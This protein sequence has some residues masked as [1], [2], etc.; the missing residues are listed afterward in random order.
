MTFLQLIHNGE[1]RST[2]H[3]LC[4][5]ECLVDMLTR[6]LNQHPR[7]ESK[8]AILDR[9]EAVVIR[10]RTEVFHGPSCREACCND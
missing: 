5:A 7:S 8:H 4:D 2:G 3:A 1:V 10:K 6:V 9:L